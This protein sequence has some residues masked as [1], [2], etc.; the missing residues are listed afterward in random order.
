MDTSLFSKNLLYEVIAL[1]EP[2]RILKETLVFNPSEIISGEKKFHFKGKVNI[3]GLGKGASFDVAALRKLFFEN[4]LVDNLGECLSYTTEGNTVDDSFSQLFGDH[5]IVTDRNLENTKKFLKKLQTLPEKSSLI[6]CLSGGGSALLELPKDGLCL[7]DLRETQKSLIQ[8]GKN[9]ME[10]NK[11][12]SLLSQVKAGGLLNFIPTRNIIELIT[13]DV[14]GN[15]LDFVSSG[16]LNGGGHIRVLIQ[17]SEQLLG[18]LTSSSNRINGGVLNTSLETALN[19]FQ[20]LSLAKNQIHISGGEI[21]IDVPSRAGVGG[22][23]TH[24][25]LALASLLYKD[26][27]NHDLKIMSMGTD[28]VDGETDAAGAFIDYSH[29]KKNPSKEY[30]KNFDSYNYFKKVGTLIKTG[31]TK[32]NVMDIRFL[33]R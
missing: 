29:F 31:P 14:P 23:N 13:S 3:F 5:P 11:G 12:R 6:F 4:G 2:Y 20:K 32:S 28:G 18:E 25:V 22:R 27:V 8:S 19:L 24:F 16:P 17:S 15:D 30:L 21:T 9:I 1:L 26:K 10:I 7:Q 33:W